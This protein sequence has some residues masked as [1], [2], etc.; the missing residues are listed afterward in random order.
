MATGK[1]IQVEESADLPDGHHF[2]LANKFPLV[3]ADGRVYGVGA[4]SHDITER[5]RAEE[6]LRESGERYRSLFQSL[7]EGFYL[8]EAILDGSGSCRDA[9][10]LEVN[11]AFERIMGLP[12]DQI[13]GKRVME[14]VPRIASEWL[15]VFG[16][17]TRTGEAVSHQAYSEVFGKHFEAFV[18]RP[19]PGQF[20]VLVTDITER[21]LAEEALRASN[22]ELTRFNEA[23]VGRELR[24]I[25]L[26][27]EINALCAQFGQPLRYGPEADNQAQPAS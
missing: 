3:A 6:A 4:I 17:V 7:Q 21:K 8:A 24:M 23:M 2:F 12:R 26:K 19:V 5:K 22:Q 13:V 18:F 16:K 27:Q 15:A 14:L 20:G 11:P 25:E 1:A 10:Y 9:I